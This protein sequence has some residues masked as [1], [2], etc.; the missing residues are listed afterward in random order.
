MRA[1]D[2]QNDRISQMLTVVTVALVVLSAVNALLITWATILDTRRPAA[3][4][5]ALGTTPAQVSAGLAVAQTLPAL[6]AAVLGIPAGIAL[7]AAVRSGGGISYPV[8]W[9][10]VL[11]LATPLA[12]AVLTMIPS[13]LAARTSPAPILRS[14]AA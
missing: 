5:R 4:A 2:P 1:P 9:L 10:A 12:V 11:A 14:E 7:Y 3:L 8:W 6:A 13:R